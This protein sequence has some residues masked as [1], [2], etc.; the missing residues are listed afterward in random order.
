MPVKQAAA[1]AIQMV[2]GILS[3]G[4]A[5]WSRDH[6]SNPTLEVHPHDPSRPFRLAFR[7]VNLKVADLAQFGTI[8]TRRKSRFRKLL[9]GLHLRKTCRRK[10]FSRKQFAASSKKPRHSSRLSGR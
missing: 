2:R 1:L 3:M 6:V 7:T 5:L 8:P 4:W 9:T 10:P